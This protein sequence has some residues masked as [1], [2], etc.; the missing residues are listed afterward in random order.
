MMSQVIG[1]DIP[2]Q[3]ATNT[4]KGEKYDAMMNWRHGE[5]D[6]SNTYVQQEGSL[7]NH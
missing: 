4:L 5:K 1:E 6:L 3:W 7:K 2:R